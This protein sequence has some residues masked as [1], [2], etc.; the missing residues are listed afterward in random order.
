TELLTSLWLSHEL[1]AD[2]R[3]AMVVSFCPAVSVLLTTPPQYPT[4]LEIRHNINRRATYDDVY[5]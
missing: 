4:L 2:S 5:P 1:T 3:Q